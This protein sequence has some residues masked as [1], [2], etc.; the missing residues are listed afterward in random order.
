MIRNGTKNDEALIYATALRCL[1]QSC[2]KNAESPSSVFFKEQHD[3]LEH[4]L[5]SSRVLVSCSDEDE[6][7]VF[8]YIVFTWDT[9]T[10]HF[11]YVKADLRRNGIATSLLT[12]ALNLEEPIYADE[13]TP[14]IRA[15]LQKH[16][17]LKVTFEKGAK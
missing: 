8:A 14:I 3:R 6:D 1:R 13:C 7:V 10:C 11:L 4:I 17:D 2:R 9:N 16:P 15:I 5:A 12:E